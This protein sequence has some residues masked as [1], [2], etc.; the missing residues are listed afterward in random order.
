MYSAARE[1]LGYY[2]G[3]F[4]VLEEGMLTPAEL[5]IYFRPKSVLADSSKV[6]IS[7]SYGL[8]IGRGVYTG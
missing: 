1:F 6:V 7:E 2:F 3:Q 5:K 4:L 8:E